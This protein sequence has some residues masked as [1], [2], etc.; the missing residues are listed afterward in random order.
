MGEIGGNLLLLVESSEVDKKTQEGLV[1]MAKTVTTPTSALVNNAHMVVQKCE[2]QFLQNK[3]V[4]AAKLTAIATQALITCTKVLAPS[5]DSQLCQEQLMEA[6]K[7]V[8]A[9][10][11]KIIMAA[12]VSL[13]THMFTVMCV[14]PTGCLWR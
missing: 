8:A 5:I 9:A 2:D 13:N 12:Q 4:H 6:C 1:I 14:M 11:E 3:V 10:V 7:L